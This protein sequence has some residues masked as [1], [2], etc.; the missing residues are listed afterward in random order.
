MGE[1]NMASFLFYLAA[2]LVPFY[3]VGGL[4]LL[5]QSKL[6]RRPVREVDLTPAEIGLEY[7]EVAFRSADGVR[8]AGWYVPAQN[9]LFTILLCHGN[10]GN[11]MHLLDSIGLF[12]SLGLSCFVF[13]YRGYD[14][15][16]CNSSPTVCPA[17]PA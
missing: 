4:L 9:A 15:C 6:L 3:A 14:S 17:E 16:R 8:L 12:H 7:E 1:L 2:I 5:L 10:G 11:I 13:D